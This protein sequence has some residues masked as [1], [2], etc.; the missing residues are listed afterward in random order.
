[1]TDA[2]RVSVPWVKAAPW[3]RGN[4]FVLNK[5]F[6][7]KLRGELNNRASNVVCN[8]LR[9]CQLRPGKTKKSPQNEE[10]GQW[11]AQRPGPLSVVVVR[12]HEVY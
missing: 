2:G 7:K 6:R 3:E 9:Q 12:I 4:L 10:R 1:M 11:T 5:E 8:E